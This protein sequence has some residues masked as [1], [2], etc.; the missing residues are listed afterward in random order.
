MKQSNRII[1]LIGGMGPYASAHF[2]ELLLKKSNYSYGAKNNDDYP[3]VLI[4][5]IPVPDFISNTKK[6]DTA[7][8]MLVSRVKKLNEFGCTSI[9]MVCNTG[10]ILYPALA[11]QSRTEFVS[12]IKLVSREAKERNYKKVGILATKTTIKSGLYKQSLTELGI[13]V[14]NPTS[15]MQNIHELIIR[16][17]V[18]GK[19]ITSHKRTLYKIAKDFITRNKLDGVILGCTELPLV[20]PKDQFNNVIDC[21]EVLSDELL[22][23]YYQ[24][25]VKYE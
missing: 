14:V 8:E 1:G 2:Y 6:L 4:D 18:A 16:D 3:E 9:A 5:S 25:G 19:N 12:M 24:K 23:M 20:F 21:L 10:H 11:K 17:V 22:E 7:K 13:T 15:S